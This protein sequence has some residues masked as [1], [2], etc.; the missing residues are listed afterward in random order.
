MIESFD[1][2]KD[3]RLMT[4]VRQLFDGAVEVDRAI[5]VSRPRDRFVGGL[6]VNVSVTLFIFA[7]RPLT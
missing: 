6:A 1:V 5:G 3:E 4:A 2:V 7:R